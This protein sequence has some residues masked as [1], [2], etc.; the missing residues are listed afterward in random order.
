MSKSQGCTLRQPA[1]ERIIFPY[2]VDPTSSALISEKDFKS[3]F[4]NAYEYLRLRKK[5][6][7]AGWR[8]VKPCGGSINAH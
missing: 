7:E 8:R 4:P 2:S 3:R 5:T 1:E 6:L